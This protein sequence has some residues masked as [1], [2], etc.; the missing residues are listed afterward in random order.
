LSN[1][2]LRDPA[3]LRQPHNFDSRRDPNVTIEDLGTSEMSGVKVEDSRVSRMIPE[4]K[5][6]ND[7]RFSTVEE[8]WHSQQLD[9]DIQVKRADPR[10][11]THTNTMT[12]IIAGEPGREIF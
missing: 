3:G 11:G 10:T 5:V 4:G 6:G 7:R 1:P 12:A 8:S 9:P 2:S